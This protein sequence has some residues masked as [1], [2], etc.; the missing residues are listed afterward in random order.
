MASGTINQ[1]YDIIERIKVQLAY[2]TG[3]SPYNNKISS[4]QIK[5]EYIDI[6]KANSYPMLCIV[7]TTIGLN[8][9]DQ[10]SSDQNVTVDVLGYV[11]DIDDPLA[12]ALKL[13]SDMENSIMADDTLNGLVYSLS[14]D[15]DVSAFTQGGF[16]AVMMSLKGIATRTE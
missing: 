10:I 2:P 6:D 7:S 15:Y 5:G 13:A 1:L 16:A 11:K 9:T 8:Q 4:D 14:I 12:T 3:S